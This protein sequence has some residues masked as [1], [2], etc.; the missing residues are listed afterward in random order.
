MVGPEEGQHQQDRQD[1]DDEDQE[2][3]AAVVL[4]YFTRRGLDHGWLSDLTGWL[5]G[6][7]PGVLESV[8][9]RA[10]SLHGA[11]VIVLRLL[12]L[13]LFLLLRLANLSQLKV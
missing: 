2:E 3:S 5:A 7:S 13:H 8:V 11:P 1:E 6:W 12:G 4:P 9:S 10:V